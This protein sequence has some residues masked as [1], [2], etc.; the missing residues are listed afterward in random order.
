MQVMRSAA[1]PV[2]RRNLGESELLVVIDP[3]SQQLLSYEDVAVGASKTKRMSLDT[4]LLSERDIMQI[5]T[6]LLDCQV[7][8]SLQLRS[9]M[10]SHDTVD[11][12]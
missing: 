1:G 10:H 7:R 6:D 12:D 11:L 4:Q 5:R 2:Q 8:G 9:L 3:I